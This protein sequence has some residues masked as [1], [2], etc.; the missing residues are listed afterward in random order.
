MDRRFSILSLSMMMLLLVPF[1]TAQVIS[2]FGTLESHNLSVNTTIT[3][4]E[5]VDLTPA[6]DQDS[7]NATEELRAIGTKMEGDRRPLLR[8]LFF[9]FILQILYFQ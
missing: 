9:S 7:K 6:W 4:M 3:A 5:F 8:V 2:S 1:S